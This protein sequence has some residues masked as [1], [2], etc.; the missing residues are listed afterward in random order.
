MEHVEQTAPSENYQQGQAWQKYSEEWYW[1]QLLG[2]VPFRSIYAEEVNSR[3]PLIGRC[4]KNLSQTPR[5]ECELRGVI[6]NPVDLSQPGTW[7]GGGA[8]GVTSPTT[9]EWM[10]GPGAT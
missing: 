5:E 8:D 2:Q 7:S 4:D 9:T 3:Q 1:D 6:T 10:Q